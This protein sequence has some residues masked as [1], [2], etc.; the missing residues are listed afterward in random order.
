MEWHIDANG[1]SGVL[2]LGEQTIDL[3]DVTS[4]YL[5]LMDDRFLP[6]VEALAADDP[7]RVHA[8]GFHEAFFRWSEVTPA[9][10]VNRAEP[11]GS[12][13]SKPY[14]AQLIA[15]HGLLPPPTLI[16]NDPEA[17]IAFR[18]EH[19]RIIYKSIS[20]SR[21]IVREFEDADVRRLDAISWCPVQFQARIEGLNVRVHVVGG[22]TFPTA[23]KSTHLDY[24]YARK[25]G[26]SSELVSTR[27]PKDIAKS[28]V[29]LTADLGL[30]FSGIDLL[31]G[32][33]GN[34]YC[35]EV[36]PSPAF[37]YFQANTGQPIA[38]AL[39]KLLAGTSGGK[40]KHR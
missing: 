33:D 34:W 30:A 25:E 19:G 20:A 5:R 14:Q 13:G 24:R 6:E 1:V 27:L 31:K 28:C 4:A 15:R 23:I 7:A 21:S 12:N 10:V 18:A 9:L 16:T 26:G 8:R 35:F 11:Q 2:T 37:S 17:V 36:N 3:S 32:S 40:R 29:A 39:A 38:T 22:R